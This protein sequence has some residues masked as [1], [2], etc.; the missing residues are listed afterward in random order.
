MDFSTVV[1][2]PFVGHR[3]TPHSDERTA[4]SRSMF[5]LSQQPTQNTSGLTKIYLSF[6]VFFL[7][8]LTTSPSMCC[9]QDYNMG[10][11]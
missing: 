9:Y 11:Q 2:R 10:Y 6:A 1:G 8:G 5:K 3:L 7:F 4:E